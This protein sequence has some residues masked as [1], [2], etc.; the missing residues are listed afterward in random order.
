MGYYDLTPDG[1]NYY[2]LYDGEIYASLG[3]NKG[4]F[5]MIKLKE[6]TVERDICDLDNNIYIKLS[7]PFN[8]DVHDFYRNFQRMIDMENQRNCHRQFLRSEGFE[9]SLTIPEANR[10][11]I[12][13]IYHNV[14]KRTTVVWFNY[15]IRELFLHSTEEAEAEKIKVKRDSED[16]DDIYMAVASAVM[17]RK[18]KSNSQFKAHIRRSMPKGFDGRPNVYQMMAAAEVSDIYGSWEKFYKIVDE[19]LELSKSSRHEL[20]LGKQI[21]KLRREGMKEK[22]IVAKLNLK[23]VTELRRLRALFVES[24][25]EV[26]NGSKRKETKSK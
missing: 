18:Y 25:R 14:E 10:Y 19:K 11:N 6:I 8:F 22:D 23:G 24:K 2:Y 9:C 26:N 5:T 4:G 12:R 1:A 16:H 3:D 7:A 13:K 21:D 20:K 17:I 15:S